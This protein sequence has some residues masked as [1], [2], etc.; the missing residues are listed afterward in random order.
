[1]LINKI[2]EKK[3][4]KE[5]ITMLTAY[6]YPLASLVDQAGIDM[7]LVGD[8]VANVVLG[9]ESTT[10]VGMF[11]MLHHAKAVRRGVKKAL[12]IGDM[13]YESYQKDV[14]LAVT[15]AKRFCDEA[16]CD[17]IKL[18]WF[19]QCVE[20]ASQIIK[21]GIPVMGHVGLTPQTAENFKVQG[22]DLQS[23]KEILARAKKLEEIGCFSIVVECVPAALAKKITESI[24]IPTI[25]IGAGVDCDGQV[26]VTNDLLG[27][28]DRFQP[29]FAKK[30]VNLSPLI[31]EGILQ[32]KKDVET[33][34]FPTQAHSFQM[35]DE[36]VKNL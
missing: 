25:G 20:V 22:K 1:M 2:L 27:L 3:K 12:V 16:G 19:D 31:L 9:L 15:N 28:F 29:K 26:L 17:A 13:P 30:Y 6:D 33:S 10:E 7:V 32:Y 5:K 8:S 11:E 21:A 35:S 36:E 4:N 18:E 34:Q 24:S 23:A 14:S